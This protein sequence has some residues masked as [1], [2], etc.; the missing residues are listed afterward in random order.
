MPRQRW[1][2][3]TAPGRRC[4]LAVHEPD[5]RRR[6]RVS[7]IRVVRFEFPY[8]DARRRIGKCGAPDCEPV[9]RATWRDVIERLGAGRAW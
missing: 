4:G 6:E 3:R 1:F 8:M 9:L 2:W 5:R 7:C